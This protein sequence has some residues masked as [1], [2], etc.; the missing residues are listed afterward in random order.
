MAGD[1]PLVPVAHFSYMWQVFLI[2]CDG[3]R[4]INTPPGPAPAS[5]VAY[6]GFATS[7]PSVLEGGMHWLP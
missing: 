1:I 7:S 3:L 6:F 2:W 4:Q 5:P